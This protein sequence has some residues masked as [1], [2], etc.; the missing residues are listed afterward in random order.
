[1]NYWWYIT[2]EP[3][4]K[5]VSEYTIKE[6]MRRSITPPS[7]SVFYILETVNGYKHN[8]KE[9]G[10]EYPSVERNDFGK[11]TEIHAIA[12]YIKDRLGEKWI[13]DHRAYLARDVRENSDSEEGIPFNPYMYQFNTSKPL[14]ELDIDSLR[15]KNPKSRKV[16]TVRKSPTCKCNKIVRKVRKK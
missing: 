6:L 14:S 16:I 11:P 4:N 7:S 13:Q 10:N 5:N 15:R 1:M 12:Q 9:K 2:S 3:T 8:I